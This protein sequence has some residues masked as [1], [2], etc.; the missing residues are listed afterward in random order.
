MRHSCEHVL[1]MAMLKFYPGLKMAMGPATD[2]GFYFDFDYDQR[3]SE[4]DFPK[5]EEEMKKIIKADLPFVQREATAEEVRKIFV[6]NPYKLEWLD[7][8]EKEN[9]K[10]ILFSTGGDFIDLCSGPHVESTGKIGPFKL[11]SIAGA[12]WRGSEKNKMLTRIYGTCFPTK[13]ELEKYLWQL[14][15]AKKRDH[16]KIGTQLGLWTF[17]ELVGTGLPLFTQKGALVRQLINDFVENLQSKQGIS[18]V[19]T[20]QITKAEL[21]KISGHYEKYRENMFEVHSHYSKEEFF[22]KPMN[23]PQHTQIYASAQ[24]SYRDL[25][26]RMADFAMLYRDEKVGE[27]IGLARTRSFSQDDCHV[28]CR[29]DQIIEEANLALDMTKKVMETYGF[30]YRYRL[31]LRDPEHP[32]KYIGEAKTWEKAQELSEQILKDRGVDYFVG[33]GEAAFYAPKLD[34]IA[35]DSIGREW[36][37]STLQIDFFMPEKFGLTYIDK[38]GKE[39][40]PVML[41]RAI[42]G[43]SERLMAILLEH[44]NGALPVWL[45]P[46]QA[47]ILPLTDRQLEHGKTLLSAFTKAEI[48]A[49][50]DDR[51]E[52]LQAK[53]RDATLQKVPY[54][55]IV[56]DREMKENKISVRTREGKDL[57]ASDLTEFIKKIKLEVE[58]KI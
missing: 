18:Q 37:L 1:M 14:E 51:N 8:I 17:S 10:P 19:W 41:H 22:L 28:F 26:I 46:V 42:C 39:Q 48:R 56:G 3:I 24:R 54:M 9:K 16:R 38:Q 15:E 49:E 25:P 21:F 31:S 50:L 5:I 40:R 13:E 43:S 52:T 36:Q 58:E 7:D 34:L 57:G 53:I 20:P 55:V 47:K 12:Y 6:D 4:S 23:C 32:E 35:T 29:E 45:S 30:N 44:Y 2:E 27:L 33:V 11:L